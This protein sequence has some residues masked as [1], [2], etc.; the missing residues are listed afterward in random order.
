MTDKEKND[1]ADS[2][3][4]KAENRDYIYSIRIFE[5]EIPA[6]L[7]KDGNLRK[8]YIEALEKSMHIGWFNNEEDAKS[9]VECNAADMNECGGFNYAIIEK[10]GWGVYISASQRWL[11]RFNREL[12]K[13]E[14]LELPEHLK[15][16]GSYDSFTYM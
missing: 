11:Y 2:L 3:Y 4:P 8:D 5:K 12:R 9:A 6:P 16:K 10:I 15:I 1:L 13:Y 7:D 14:E